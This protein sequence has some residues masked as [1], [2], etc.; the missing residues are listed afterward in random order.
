MIEEGP[1][2]SEKS[3]ESKL[4]FA[5]GF[6]VKEPERPAISPEDGIHLNITS[7][8][9]EPHW[10][11]S[12]KKLLQDAI[13]AIGVAKVVAQGKF[14]QDFWVNLHMNAYEKFSRGINV[15]G[16]NPT[17]EKAWGRPVEIIPEGTGKSTDMQ[18]MNY[19]R[20][21]LGLYL[22]QLIDRKRNI[23]LFENGIGE[24][25]S[26]SEESER[27]Q[28]PYYKQIW[29]NENFKLILSKEP[30]LDGFHLMVSQTES[31]K[32]N[33]GALERLWQEDEQS[34]QSVLEMTAILMGMERLLLQSELN[35]YNPE[36]HFSG[37]WSKSFVESG[38]VNKLDLS[39]LEGGVDERKVAK[40]KHRANGEMAFSTLVHGHLYGTR[41][42]TQFVKLMPRPRNEIPEAYENI[43]QPSD[44]EILFIEKSARSLTQWLE[45]NIQKHNSEGEK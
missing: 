2:E 3:K 28:S 25:P 39:Y 5:N 11:V 32:K 21:E 6:I 27:A 31:Y 43:P 41:L 12:P 36:I 20:R 10:L 18:T 22:P 9:E 34:T 45:E 4:L 1:C 16:R 15:Y 30:H 23:C 29:A 19:L 37:N 17:S 8:E 42:P 7:G 14:T 40:A 13:V 44:Q 33:H 24:L 26:G 35:F 38:K